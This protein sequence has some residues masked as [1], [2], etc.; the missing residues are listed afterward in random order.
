M[1]ESYE[2][3]I[4]V[5][6]ELRL[7]VDEQQDGEKTHLKLQWDIDDADEVKEITVVRTPMKK[8]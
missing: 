1:K 7:K 6:N 4:E 8:N 3:A 2:K 5:D